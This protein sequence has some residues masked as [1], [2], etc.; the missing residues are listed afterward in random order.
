METQISNGAVTVEAEPVVSDTKAEVSL[1]DLLNSL[2]ERLKSKPE[3]VEGE[4]VFAVQLS[5]LHPWISISST[6][7]DHQLYGEAQALFVECP[8]G[9]P[10]VTHLPPAEGWDALLKFF[11]EL[12]V[13]SRLTVKTYDQDSPEPRLSVEAAL[14]WSL[15]TLNSLEQVVKEVSLLGGEVN[16]FLKRQ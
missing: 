10:A 5:H 7:V 4:G 16:E 8:I 12:T 14:P 15:V 2:S 9:N 11:G 6:G 13:F 3:I 1:A